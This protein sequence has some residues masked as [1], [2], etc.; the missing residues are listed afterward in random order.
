[1]NKIVNIFYA[2]LCVFLWGLL[3]VWVGSNGAS[4]SN[5][6]QALSLAIIAAGALAS[7]GN[8]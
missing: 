7:G 6:V 8:K 2:L 3:M 5:D 4:V 1:M